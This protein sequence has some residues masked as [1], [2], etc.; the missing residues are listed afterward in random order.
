MLPES[1]LVS[2][3]IPTH[4][5][6]KEYEE[7]IAGKAP[8]AMVVATMDKWSDLDW[9]KCSDYGGSIVCAEGD[10]VNCHHFGTP[11]KFDFPT[12]W[13]GVVRYL[14]P[15]LC[16]FQCNNG[17]VDN[18]RGFD[19]NNSRLAKEIAVPILDLD[20]DRATD[21]Q[22]DQ[23]GVEVGQW[24]KL[25]N[26]CSYNRDCTPGNCRAQVALPGCTCA[27]TLF[28]CTVKTPAGNDVNW[29]RTSDFNSAEER[30]APY[31]TAFKR[32]DYVVK[33]CR[34]QCFQPS[35]NIKEILSN[36]WTNSTAQ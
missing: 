24:L 7:V 15:A 32:H 13:Q 6:E 3:R 20:L 16:S 4:D 12:V 33:K 10:G 2:L 27:W 35:S 22:L 1:V 11:Y 5:C 29:G 25:N 34:F 14:K 31:Y 9:S 36:F 18:G 28:E 26:T 21:E 17:F 30:L 23:L 19:V 8:I